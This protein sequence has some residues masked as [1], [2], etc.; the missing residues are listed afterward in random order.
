MGTNLIT[1]LAFVGISFLPISGIGCK[2]S[3]QRSEPVRTF[4]QT[5][6]DLLIVERHISAIDN[7][8]RFDS[9]YSLGWGMTEVPPRYRNFVN[10][11]KANKK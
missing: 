10:N 8:D 2:K 3:E 7:P 6:R 11:Y 1:K 9:E 5:Q 4:E